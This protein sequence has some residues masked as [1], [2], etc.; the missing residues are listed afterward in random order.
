M[1]QP[2]TLRRILEVLEDMSKKM[3]PPVD[4]VEIPV[5]Y[6]IDSKIG[7]ELMVDF[8]QTMGYYAKYIR[9]EVDTHVR[10]ELWIEDENF[11]IPWELLPNRV[12]TITQVVRKI[13]IK[14]VDSSD[15]IGL[16][17]M[18]SSIPPIVGGTSVYAAYNIP[19]GLD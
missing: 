7:N 3:G 15:D 18:A 19:G 14:A 8:D 11:E 10:V 16:K 9:L 6:V 13:K 2:E 5:P 1:N 17:L 12:Y 4:K